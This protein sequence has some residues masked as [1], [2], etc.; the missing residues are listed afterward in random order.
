MLVIHVINVPWAADVL[1]FFT[2]RS[3]EAE[4]WWETTH[5]KRRVLGMRVKRFSHGKEVGS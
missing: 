3:V 4:L 5:C 2:A 1:P